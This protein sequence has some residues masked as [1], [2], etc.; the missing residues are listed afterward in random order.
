[1]VGTGAGL[2][3]ENRIPGADCNPYLAYAASIASGLAGIERRIEPPDEFVGDVYHA[4]NLLRV[5][6][7]LEHATALFAGPAPWMPDMF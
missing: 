1:M 6:R 3:I 4:E 7:T 2:R 5:P